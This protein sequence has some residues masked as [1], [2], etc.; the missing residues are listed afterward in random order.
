M[1]LTL[2]TLLAYLDD[3]LEPLEIKTIGQK[4]AE[5]ETA[6]ELIA[7]IKQVTRRR[8]ITTPPATGPNSFDPNTVSD[9][10]DNE[11][12]SEQVAEVEKLC[13]ESDVHLAEV[14]ACHQILT[15]VLG[16]PAVVPPTAKERMYGLVQGREAIPFRKAKAGTHNSSSTSGD[17]DDDDLYLL[18][19]PFY[20]Q[21]GWLRWA[22]PIGAVLLFLIVGVALWQ[23]MSGEQQPVASHQ[24]AQKSNTE[25]NAPDKLG[26]TP[27]NSQE[28][29]VT[30]DNNGRFAADRGNEDKKQSAAA[31]P[32]TSSST[33]TKQPAQT[34]TEQGAPTNSGGGAQPVA[35]ADVTPS[36]GGLERTPGRAQGTGREAPPSKE[37][38]VVGKY[39][40]AD[41]APPSLL[42]QRKESDAWTRVKPGSAVSTGDQLMSLPGYASEVR[43]DKGVNLL[44]RGHVR[45]FTPSDREA[46]AMDHLQE[47]AIVL[48][49]PKDTDVDLTL[50]RGRLYLSNHK[51]N[52]SRGLT[53]RLRFENKAWDLTLQPDSEVLVDLLK[54]RMAGTGEP[55]TFLKL[56]LL[57]GDAG[58][59]LERER[60]PDLSDPGR[61]Q[62][63]WVSLNPSTYDRPK[64]SAQELDFAKRVL[65]P[66]RFMA[67][68]QQAK[69]MELALKAIRDRMTVDK[70]PQVAL[71]ETLN[72][73]Q[74][75]EHQLAL[76]CL[77]A[78]DEAKDLL[79][80]LGK[81]DLPHG[82]D[83]D[84]AIFALRR[85]LDHGP[86]QSERLFDEKSGKGLLRADLG[87]TS[88][89]SKRIIALLRDPTDEDIFNSKYYSAMAEDL[90]SD[91]VAV[92]ELAR[93]WL[94]RIALL[95]FRLDLPNLK[96]FNAAWPQDKRL[97]AKQ[98][99]DQAIR[100][101]R[102][103]PAEG[104]KARAPGGAQQP[105]KK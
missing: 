9:Y 3:T 28:K 56:F 39:Y 75:S 105:P 69:S 43:L 48:H 11:L 4:V 22:L 93:W 53:V 35:R 66:K 34:K 46:R 98:E 55:L 7:R 25:E 91:K 36:P 21:G 45:E 31:Q 59:A 77:A 65:F 64:L 33:D 87:Y 68:T 23:L 24:V 40:V 30:P 47:S 67:D 86:G 60:Y 8:R 95:L 83:R 62:F 20:R 72:N 101:G 76:Y 103:P 94:S 57:N 49:S 15:L 100:D 26:K 37:R 73:N 42:V 10:L 61:A 92:A 97:K 85:W 41:N 70:P 12:S 14:A 102:L 52:E 54:S 99:V 63:F 90:A 5:S 27:A 78:L 58:I 16:E 80:V 81:A 88:Q 18:G 51:A 104:G 19:L 89:E 96:S 29:V 32:S 38:A 79:D 50:L 2:R 17:A 82:L 6:Q 13:L 71:Q 84:N 44:L 74:Y 1:R